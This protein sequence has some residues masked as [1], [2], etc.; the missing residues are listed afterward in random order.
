MNG[1]LD[2][3]VEARALHAQRLRFVIQIPLMIAATFAPLN[4]RAP[5]P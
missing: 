4:G 5:R 2:P 3:R 1:L